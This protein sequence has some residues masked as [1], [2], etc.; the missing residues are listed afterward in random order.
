V[1]AGGRNDTV[2]GNLFAR[3]GSWAVLVVPF[4]DTDTPPPISHCEG[5]VPN[6]LNPGWCYYATWGNKVSHNLFLHNGGFGNPTN[7][8]LADLSELHDPGNCWHGNRD[9]A[10]VTTAPADLQR[11]NRRCGV[12]H[13]GAAILGSD[14]SNQ[15]ICASEIFGPCPP[16]PGMSYPRATHIVMPALRRQATMPEPCRGV[17]RNP[18]CPRHRSDD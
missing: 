6:F 16:T 3:N 15:V 5:G 2:S 11:T 8:D 13:Q 4:I 14:L 18:W 10:G 17:P 7:G 1:I 9:P 12:P